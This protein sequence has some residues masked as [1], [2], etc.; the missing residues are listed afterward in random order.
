MSN[1]KKYSTYYNLLY[2]DKN[3]GEEVEYVEKLIK[4]HT[5]IPVTEI[6]DM[7]SGTGRHDFV[8]AQ[9]NYRVTGIDLSEEMTQIALSACV[10]NT[11]FHTGDVRSIEINKQFDAVISLFH[12]ASYQTTNEDFEKYLQ[13]AK[14][15]LKQGGVFIFDFWYGP[16]VLSDKP[17]TR[18]K[19]LENTEIKITRLTES[20]ILPNANTVNVNFEM[21]IEDKET[22]QLTK[23]REL[24]PMRYWFLPE[25]EYFCKHVGFKI[26]R[27]YN[28]FSE[29]KLSLES[30]YGV[31]ILK[32]I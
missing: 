9:K 24:H 19:R 26:E 20:E 1:F 17:T 11:E 18:I 21:L 30:W 8:F 29:N 22:G 4:R 23:T 6:L 13:S 14:K 27:S 15:H 16:A 10:K 31:L 2:Q 25:I 12:V 32:K 5:E 7:G 28:W 3:Y